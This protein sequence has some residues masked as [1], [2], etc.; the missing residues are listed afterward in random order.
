[1]KVTLENTFGAA[2]LGSVAATTC[3]YRSNPFSWPVSS[4]E[5]KFRIKIVWHHIGAGLQ[6]L[7]QLSSRLE[8][9]EICGMPNSL[10]GC[11]P[12]FIPTSSF[13]VAFLLCVFKHLLNIF[14]T[15]SRWLDIFHVV[16]TIVAIYHYLID[17]FGN[18]KAL[19]HISW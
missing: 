1:M 11:M 8:I 17:E 14:L 6:L 9:P 2:L 13:Q 16:F 7:P 15:D 3:V 4:S 18:P 5:P 12:T 19:Q 10:G